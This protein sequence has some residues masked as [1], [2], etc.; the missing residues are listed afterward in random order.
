V[1]ILFWLSLI[2]VLYTYAGYPVL[3]WLL[4]RLRPWP[5]NSAR[6]TPSVSIVLAVHNGA[7]LLAAKIQHLL[8]VDY[9]N[10]KEIILVSDGS[11]DSTADLL[12]AQRHPLIQSIILNEHV[13]K[14]VAVT[15]GA[16]RATA[17]VI[18]F[19]DIRPEI[20]PGAI[21]ELVG[22]FADPNVGCVAGGPS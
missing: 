19:V 10:I 4:A 2:G 15:A 7:A 18:L 11:T 20:A 3:I 12:R 6:I 1:K 16:A 8:A 13:G 22:N 21:Q 14:A 17:D 5:T 9:P